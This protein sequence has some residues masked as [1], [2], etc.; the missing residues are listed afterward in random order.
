MTNKILE[1]TEKIYNEGVVKAKLE[2][3]KIIAEAKNKAGEIIE[4]AK[5]Q[6]LEIIEQAKNQSAEYKKNTDSEIQLAARQ[7]ISKLKQQIT[8]LVTVAQI[9]SPVEEAFNDNE[10]IKSI[11]LIL[12]KNWN[13]QKPEEFKL[14]ILL[15]KKDE[16]EFSE[17]F[18]TKAIN[19]LT[20]GIDINF[21]DKVNNGFKIG[22]KDGSFIISFSDTDF[23]NYF[24]GYMK[25]R[26]KK[27]LFES[28]HSTA[29]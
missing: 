24:K 15:P 10:F 28:S 4:S 22:P 13:P 27:L 29:D 18:E 5:K 25:E 17:F 8:N 3:D 1:I 19:V 21:D 14:N 6:E 7:F 23:E 2:A 16:K 11:I 20:H 9:E 12:I 26:T